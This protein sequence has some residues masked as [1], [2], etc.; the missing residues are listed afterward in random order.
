M[1]GLIVDPQQGHIDVAQSNFARKY[2][3]PGLLAELL[4]SRITVMEQTGKFWQFG[5]QN[6]QVPD[7]P[8]RAPGAAAEQVKQTISKASYRAEDYSLARLITQEERANFQAGNVDQWATEMLTDRILLD[9]ENRIANLMGLAA[10]YPSGNKVVLSGTDQWKDAG[11]V[12]GTTSN[13]IDD[14][15]AGHVKISEIGVKA[16]TLFLGVDTWR[17]LKTHADIKG[18]VSPT[19]FGAVSTEDM[20]AIFEVERVLVGIPV[21]VTLNPDGTVASVARLWDAKNAIL[22][23]VN[24]GA[25][26]ED[27]SF[28]KL[29]VWA[30]PGTS[31]GFGTVIGPA[32][33]PSRQ[34]DE[35]SVH[36]YYDPKITSDISA[37]FIENAVA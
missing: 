2:R 19:K 34:A 21:K 1:P 17:G 28:G 9:L 6:Q 30:A 3:N 26:F 11:A 7:N 25:S 27:V 4:F 22:A 8:L 35:L 29:F 5:R 14:V 23:Y 31:G 10:T 16:N 12:D 20:A 36:F 15:M 24:P 13:P 33:W 32:P 37:Y 18:R